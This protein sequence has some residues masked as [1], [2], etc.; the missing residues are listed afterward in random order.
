MIYNINGYEISD[1]RVERF[2]REIIYSYKR[3][4]T[5]GA[6]YT[7]LVI[8]QINSKGEKQ[9]PFVI[10]PNY[11]NGGTESAYPIA[12][13]EDYEVIINAGRYSEP[14]GAGVAVT[15]LPRGTV[16]QN[17]IVLQQGDSGNSSPTMDWVLTINNVGVL[18]YARYSDSAATMV[19]NGI[20]SAVSGFIP[21]LSNY[22]AIDDIETTDISY[23]T[24][25]DDTQHQ[26]LGQYDNGDY[27]VITTE[28]RG[29][30]GGNWFTM[31]QLQ[32][33]CKELGL[34][35]AFSL[36]GGG[37]AETIIGKKQFNPFYDNDYGRVNPTFIIFNGTTQFE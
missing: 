2:K 31:K 13:R 22:M 21:I 28:G 12:L 5:T 18:G 7:H 25:T 30:Q 4:E 34:K 33:L 24:R 6:F 27:A 10:W 11:P 36:D 26:V 1:S 8:P 14:Y 17:S 9:Y 29:Y 15:G 32:T 23:I 37:S 3:D 19:A 16:I 20:V 35:F